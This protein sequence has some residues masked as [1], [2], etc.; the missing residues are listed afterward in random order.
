MTV[1]G[2]KCDQRDAFCY[3]EIAVELLEN[4]LKEILKKKLEQKKLYRVHN[5]WQG[6]KLFA[7]KHC[8]HSKYCKNKF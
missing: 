6:L 5:I 4:V 3:K 7:N 8:L 1:Y 2:P